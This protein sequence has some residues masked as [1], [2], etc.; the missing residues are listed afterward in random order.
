MCS[1]PI[2]HPNPSSTAADLLLQNPLLHRSGSSPPRSVVHPLCCS[3][4]DLLL[5]RVYYCLSRLLQ[6]PLL[7]LQPRF[8][9]LLH[10]ASF[11]FFRS[12]LDLFGDLS[13]SAH[14]HSPIPIRC[15]QQEAFF[16]CPSLLICCVSARSQDL[17]SPTTRWG[18]PLAF[19]SAAITAPLLF[20][21]AS[22]DLPSSKSVA[23][24]AASPCFCCRSLR[25]EPLLI[26]LR[27][28]YRSL[29]ENYN[30]PAD[31]LCLQATVCCSGLT[32]DHLFFL[33]CD[34]NRNPD[35]VCIC[36][37]LCCYRLLSL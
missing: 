30:R 18:P 26:P 37:P 10:A 14:L 17:P 21:P 3:R 1:S 8:K 27:S 12:G 24:T 29:F 36:P 34:P 9:H 4:P 20:F 16:C 22:L 28:F 32:H 11:F 25:S 7:G 33:D 23:F 19:R 31:S 5:G 2:W 13:P 15:Q 35:L 6:L